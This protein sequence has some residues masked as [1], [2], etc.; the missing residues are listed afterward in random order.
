MV[1]MVAG[2]LWCQFLAISARGAS[3]SFSGFKPRQSYN[4]PSSGLWTAA[5]D[6]NGD[7]LT[8]LAVGSNGAN[9]LATFYAAPGGFTTPVYTTTN[10]YPT[11]L[12][13]GD[14]NGDGR[15]D[16][17]Y[18]DL[19]SG[20]E[21]AYGKSNSTFSAPQSLSSLDLFPDGRLAMADVNGDGHLDIL[22]TSTSSTIQ[23]GGVAIGYGNG[24]G[25]VTSYSGAP[26]QSNPLGIAV[27]DLNRD[28]LPDIILGDEFGG[29]KVLYQGANGTF[30][31]KSF[32]S[33]RA[34]QIVTGDFNDDGIPDIAFPAWNSNAIGVMLGQPNG[35]LGTASYYPATNSPDSI[36]M[37]DFNND[38]KLDLVVSS[39]NSSTATVMLGNGDGTFGSAITLQASATGSSSVS[40]GDFDD[41]GYDDIAIAAASGHT[42]DVFYNASI[43]VPEPTTVVPCMLLGAVALS[44]R[45]ARWRACGGLP[46]DS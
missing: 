3:Q 35:N 44:R 19:N 42:L 24:A 22:S 34:Y 28:G 38:G 1:L 15:A 43:S 16:L 39:Q 36:A 6:F 32:S 23:G 5:G 9:E 31:E 21:I 4:L 40:V 7:G 25:G 27:A 33:D 17:V 2:L 41:N 37:G 30:T 20:V 11:R 46:K 26:S 12:V 29:M 45:A 10:S 14:F 18:F 8:D 13:C